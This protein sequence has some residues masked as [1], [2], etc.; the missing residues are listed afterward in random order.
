M[1][2]FRIKKASGLVGHLNIQFVY[3]KSADRSQHDMD[4]FDFLNSI[5]V[6]EDSFFLIEPIFFYNESTQRTA[7][8]Q[9]YYHWGL[10]YHDL[11]SLKVILQEVIELRESI[12]QY[13]TSDTIQKLSFWLTKE[14]KKILTIR[15]IRYKYQNKMIA[16][17]N[18][19]SSFIEVALDDKDIKGIWVIGI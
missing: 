5:Y 7:E 11:N 4:K 6:K 8:Q 19:I 2:D 16:Y 12:Q 13:R 3:D 15:R 17:L 14:L 1:I 9:K 10:N 18:E